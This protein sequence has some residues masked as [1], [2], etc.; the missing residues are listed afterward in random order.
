[1]IVATTTLAM[2]VNTPAQSVVIAGLEHPDS[3]PYAVAEYKNLVGRAGRLGFAERG[4]S[5]LV[6]MT[7]RDAQDFWDRYVTALPEHL[8]LRFLEPGTDPRSLIVRVLV[9]GGRATGAG[10]PGMTAEQIATF[11]EASFGAFQ[12]EQRVGRWNW[13]HAELLASVE[14]SARHGLLERR[15][16]GR[17]ELT[18]LGRLAGESGTEVGSVVRLV[19]CLRPLSPGQINDPTLLAA[20]QVTCELDDVYI[21]LNK[22]T[23][24]EAQSWVSALVSQ[25][26]AQHVLHCLARDINEQHDR[27]ARAKRAVAALAFVSGQEINEIERLL[28]RHGGSFD[29]A[30][31]P[32]RSVAA[33]T[34]DLLGTAARVAEILHPEL[35]FGDRID[36]LALRLTLACQGP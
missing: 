14:E 31:G 35:D 16:E 27:A 30:A 36:R 19:E 10:R 26:V 25:G 3:S 20:V 1:M 13:S 18:L 34:C 22:K 5:Y 4:S 2:G 28:A 9:A 6:A 23:P 11:L 29:G 17:F 21:Y 15:E 24:K 8:E 32:V 33:R 7:P 12:E